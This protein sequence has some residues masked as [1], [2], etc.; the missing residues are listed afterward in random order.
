MAKSTTKA[1]STDFTAEMR[2]VVLYGK[3]PL[4]IADA[5]RV[6]IDTLTEAFGEVEQFRFNGETA[7]LADVFDELRSYGLMQQHKLVI[8]DNAAE[9]VKEDNRPPVERYTEN[10]VE[11]A[12]LLLRGDLWRGGNLDKKIAKV[13]TVRKFD[14][15]SASAATSWVKSRAESA[16]DVTIEPNAATLLVERLGTS[17]TGLDTELGKLSAIVGD[18]KQGITRA[19]VEEM[20]GKSREEQAW[21]VQAAVVSGR[22]DVAL[23]KVRELMEI[24]RVDPVPISWSFMDLGRKLYGCSRLLRERQHPGAIAKRYKLWGP[25]QEA[26][27][28][29]ARKISPDDAAAI[30]RQVVQADRKMK[31]GLANGVRSVEAQAVLLADRFR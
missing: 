9:F 3:E 12:T 5:T 10:P 26:V 22:P 27:L 31:S 1:R 17:L 24:S 13:G 15:L 16:H 4:L 29:A 20:V 14:A 11:H 28:G 7:T 8:V 23:R 18:A 30:F 2:V 21:E 6:L 25:M 19:M